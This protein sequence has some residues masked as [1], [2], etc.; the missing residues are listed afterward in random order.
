MIEWVVCAATGK[1]VGLAGRPLGLKI[2]VEF[3]TAWMVGAGVEITQSSA[4]LVIF[5]KNHQMFAFIET[6][7]RVHAS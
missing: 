2:I 5:D 3:P 4:Y 7:A 6:S 1:S